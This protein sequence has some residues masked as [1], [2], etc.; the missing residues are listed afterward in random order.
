MAINQVNTLSEEQNFKFLLNQSSILHNIK[1]NNITVNGVNVIVDKPKRGDIMC[2]TRLPDSNG[3][4]ATDEQKIVWVDGLSVNLKYLSEEYEPVGICVSIKGNKAMVRYKTETKET[5][6]Y[7]GATQSMPILNPNDPC[8]YFYFNNGYRFYEMA[9][10]CRAKYYDVLVEQN[11][12]PSSAMTDITGIYGYTGSYGLA[13]SPD[14][15]SKNEYCQILRDNFASYD[16]Y[17]DSMFVKCPCGAGGVIGQTIYGKE[18]TH[19]S[20]EKISLSS[21]THTQSGSKIFSYPAARLTSN[22]SISNIILSTLLYGEKT[23][24]IPSAAEMVE[25]MRDV[26]YGTSFWATNPDIV[27]S[28]LAKLN[29]FDSNWSMLSASNAE[30][31]SIE[32]WT[33]SMYSN[34]EAYIYNGLSGMLSKLQVENSAYVTP[35]TIV[36]F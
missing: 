7:P 18:N 10:C 28:V 5:F 24:W 22:I 20:D 11:V 34:D 8:T 32:R 4:I 15:F 6:R 21:F 2:N 30:N 29:S 16:E 26:T 35:I 14:A 9:P 13:A 33:S 31:E 36:S 25:M 17:F 27:N 3:I 1:T 19:G 23:W 12:K